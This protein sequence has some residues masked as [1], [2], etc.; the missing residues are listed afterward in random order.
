MKG[1][2]DFMRAW[3]DFCKAQPKCQECELN[4]KTCPMPEMMTDEEINRLIAKVSRWKETQEA[5]DES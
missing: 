3:R 2:I 4:L 1:A 5:K